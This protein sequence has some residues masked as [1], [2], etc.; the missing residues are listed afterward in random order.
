MVTSRNVLTSGYSQRKRTF[1]TARKKVELDDDLLTLDQIDIAACWKIYQLENDC[2]EAHIPP[3]PKTK[4]CKQNPY[5]IHRLGLEKFDKLSQSQKVNGSSDEMVWRD[6]NIQPC[7]L[8][9]YG[10]YCYVNSFIQIWFNDLEFRKCIYNWR[11]DP[12]W[13][14]PITAKFDIQ[15]VM[16]CMQRLFLTLQLTPFPTTD[17]SQL[18]ELLRLNN[19]QQDVQEFHIL[20]FDSIERELESHPNGAQ[21]Q[22]TIR[23]LFHSRMSQTMQCPCGK[24]TMVQSEYRSLPISIEGFNSLQAAIESFFTPEILADYRCSACDHL[25]ETTKTMGFLELPKVLIIQLTRYVFDSAKE[26]HRKLNIAIPY[27]RILK[28]TTMKPDA[29]YNDLYELSA[30]MIHEGPNT[31]CGHYYDLI[32]DPHSKQWFVYNDKNV[33]LEK[34]TP[35]YEGNKEPRENFRAT[36]DQKGCYALIY[37]RKI[38][39]EDDA[40]VADDLKLP[41]E[42]MVKEVTDQLYNE[43]NQRNKENNHSRSLWEWCIGNKHSFFSQLYRELEVKNGRNLIDTPEEIAFLP[44]SFLIDMFTKEY[45]ALKEMQPLDADLIVSLKSRSEEAA[46]K[47]VN[48]ENDIGKITDEAK[49]LNDE[50]RLNKTVRTEDKLDLDNDL[51]GNNKSF[52]GPSS[53]SFTEDM[54]DALSHIYTPEPIND[55]NFY[56][57]K[58]GHIPLEAIR[59]GQLKAVR[60]KAALRII[61][62]YNL[63]WNV[64]QPEQKQN[65][66]IL[67]NI[68]DENSKLDILKEQK[69]N[70]EIEQ[71]NQD[72]NKQLSDHRLRTG[73]DLCTEC[74]Q[75]LKSNA[76]FRHTLS[77][78]EIYLAETFKTLAKRT[79]DPCHDTHPQPIFDPPEDAIWVSLDHLKRFKKIALMQMQE[80]GRLSMDGGMDE[81]A[82]KRS[83]NDSEDDNISNEQQNQGDENNEIQIVHEHITPPTLNSGHCIDENSTT[84][85]NQDTPQIKEQHSEFHIDEDERPGTS[86]ATM[87]QTEIECLSTNNGIDQKSGQLDEQN[88]I[89]IIDE[90]VNTKQK[91]PRFNEDLLCKHGDLSYKT[92]RVWLTKQSWSILANNFVDICEPIPC[93]TPECKECIDEYKNL[94]EVRDSNLNQLQALTNDIKLLINKLAVRKWE[95]DELGHIWKYVLCREYVNKMRNIYARSKQRQVVEIPKICQE[96]LLCQHGRP[97]LV[98]CDGNDNTEASITSGGIS[99]IGSNRRDQTSDIIPLFEAEW[100]E[101]VTKYQKHVPEHPPPQPILLQKNGQYEQF[102]DECH[103]QHNM[104]IETRRYIYPEGAD[105]YVKF[106]EDESEEQLQARNAIVSNSTLTMTTRRVTQKNIIKVKMHSDQTIMDLKLALMSKTKQS[107]NDQLIYLNNCA[108]D[109]ALTLEEAR[110][111]SNNSDN[112]LVLIVQHRTDDSDC[113]GSAN[114]GAT[115]QNRVE[116]NRRLEKGFR[117][118]AL[119]A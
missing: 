35:G 61:K 116:K 72:T 28:A 53:T 81:P 118:T 115:Q 14:K 6:S 31:H 44:T 50:Q 49:N 48:N 70:G 80:T 34:R 112:P 46:V 93:S 25:G 23:R 98:L 91:P 111:A 96:C 97:Y 86:A 20:F 84:F 11:P 67:Q 75:E 22:A 107:P 60:T 62:Q 8:V 37:H 74:V 104:N 100:D 77:Q 89:T 83:K 52:H 1:G 3:N 95:P 73:A 29:D 85:D 19:E 79:H 16:C 17:A 76:L 27:P 102:C 4:N 13:Q 10:N 103:S 30:V 71:T 113:G 58:H 63:R 51:H 39:V 106:K 105:I 15:E 26:R 101:L 87:N 18:I 55:V 40:N 47:Q 12:N 5:C 82:E 119:S 94:Q 21:I 36:A 64:S 108:L 24:T 66:D 69:H 32:R 110:V 65:D 7:G 78:T 43:F 33:Q 2:C 42:N 38:A 56:L 57:C 54:C 45:N 88:Q 59:K 99:D 68:T 9:N 114:D 117:D 109:N 41:P 92:K 90:E